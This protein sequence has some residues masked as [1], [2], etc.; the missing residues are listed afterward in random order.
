MHMPFLY[1]CNDY[2]YHSK[3]PLSKILK[4]QFACAV[5]IGP[6]QLAKSRKTKKRF[7]FNYKIGTKVLLKQDF[8]MD[9]VNK[10]PCPI[11]KVYSD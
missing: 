5:H 11:I 3:N 7:K 10:G 8:N 9:Y 2:C 4:I 1:S 6:W